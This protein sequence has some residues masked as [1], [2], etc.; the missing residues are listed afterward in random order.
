[1]RFFFLKQKTAYEM[2]ISDWSSDGCSSDLRVRAV[3]RVDR[4]GQFARRLDRRPARIAV[5]LVARDP[6]PHLVVE[7]L[8][9]RD[10]DRVAPRRLGARLCIAALA[11]PRA[12]DHEQRC[13]AHP[14][15]P[16]I[17]SFASMSACA[18][19]SAAIRSEEHTSELQSLMR[20][21]YAVFCLQ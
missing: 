8:G 10:K 5:G 15:I 6:R 13:A 1:M 2:R 21:S 17:R 20:S 14:P 3:Q 18:A 9:G 19:N 11:R 7:R 16:A 12:A 4:G